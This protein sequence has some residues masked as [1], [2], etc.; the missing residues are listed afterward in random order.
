MMNNT[1]MCLAVVMNV[2]G[3]MPDCQPAGYYAAATDGVTDIGDDGGDSSNEMGYIRWLC[4][5][6]PI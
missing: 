6:A 5:S 2:W 4:S 3:C 1:V